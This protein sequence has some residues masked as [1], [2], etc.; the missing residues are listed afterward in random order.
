MAPENEDDAT[1]T[2]SLIILVAYVVSLIMVG[3]ALGTLLHNPAYAWLAI[4]VGIFIPTFATL[5]GR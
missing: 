3:G 5:L 1:A 4:G 2:A